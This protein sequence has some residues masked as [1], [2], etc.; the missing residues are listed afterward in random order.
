[1]LRAALT[2]GRVSVAGGNFSYRTSL[3]RG[4]RISN[5][6]EVSG[7]VRNPLQ[8]RISLAV[9]VVD[10]YYSQERV[11]LHDEMDWVCLAFSVADAGAQHVAAEDL[12]VYTNDLGSRHKPGLIGRAVPANV[13]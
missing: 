13:D 9:V 10:I 11:G 5:I 3:R 1:M 2:L 7:C 8:C 4:Q 12:P 6:V